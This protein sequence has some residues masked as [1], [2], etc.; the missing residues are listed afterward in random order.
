MRAKPKT[1]PEIEVCGHDG[2]R[3]HIRRIPTS[4]RLGTLAME[5]PSGQHPNRT[6][7]TNENGSNQGKIVREK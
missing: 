4:Q 1:D 2:P 3:E 6:L 7:R 5:L